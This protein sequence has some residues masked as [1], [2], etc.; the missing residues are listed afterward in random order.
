MKLYVRIHKK[1]MLFIWFYWLIYNA[2]I[3][4]NEWNEI[5]RMWTLKFKVLF[6]DNMIWI[7][8]LPISIGNYSHQLLILV[9]YLLIN[10]SAFCVDVY[11]SYFDLNANQKLKNTLK[12]Y[13]LSLVFIVS[14]I[15]NTNHWRVRYVST[16]T[17]FKK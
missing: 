13:G 7:L 11:C 15:S 6:C 5:S 16:R 1:E 4:I 2:I 14:L 12:K 17:C 3:V 9:I 10:Y 8:E